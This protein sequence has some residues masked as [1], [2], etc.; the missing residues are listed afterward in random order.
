MN[1]TAL[2]VVAGVAGSGKSTLGRALAERCQAVLLDQDILTNPL[3]VEIARLVGASDHDLDHPAL[4]SAHI[5]QARYRCLLDCALSNVEIGRSVVLVAPFTAEIGSAASWSAAFAAF[6]SPP[7]LLWVSVP[8]EVAALRRRAR[9]L[10]R[11]L[12]ADL[13]RRPP[14]SVL[15]AVPYLDVDGTLPTEDALALITGRLAAN[16]ELLTPP[17]AC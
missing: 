15:P 4:A 2:Y 16:G 10:P 11:D 8:P 9:A 7:V 1:T 3:M 5:R 17:P 13:T 6:P 12:A 14:A